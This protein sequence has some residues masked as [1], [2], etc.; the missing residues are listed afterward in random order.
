MS[1]SPF[2]AQ[3]TADGA[4]FE[5]EHCLFDTAPA[6][7]SDTNLLVPLTPYGFVE[8]TGPDGQ[9][10]FQGQTTADFRQVSA[11]QA[12]PGSYCTPKGRMLASFSAARLDED[13]LLLQMRKD[14]IEDTL[15][16][17]AKYAVFSKVKLS[18][19]SESYTGIGL[20][21]PDAK[22]LLS[23]VCETTPDGPLK[24]CA[25]PG[26]IV[27][28]CDEAGQRYELWL[29]PEQAA[30]VWQ[31]LS[32]KAQA[33]SSTHWDGLRIAAGDVPVVAATRDEFLPQ[34]LNYD[35]TG[36]VNFK[37]GCYT[38]QEVV[39]RLHFK[40]VPKR[41]LYLARLEGPAKAGEEVLDGEKTVGMVA[42]SGPDQQVALVLAT[43][44]AD[45]ANL[46]LKG[47]ARVV[48]VTPPPYGF[49]AE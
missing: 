33:V 4:R 37:K 34:F 39:A 3:L 5:G 17:L 35:L 11:T 8:A 14:L 10:F 46:Q 30:E 18:D 40:G 12:R 47:G 19:A 26:G 9:T 31:A 1:T 48:E 45:S 36:A 44:S 29:K 42:L 43:A 22:A 24:T 41:R 6:S 2:I 25:L 27:V 32:S 23:S 15:T 20:V 13:T 28:Q 21:G 49:P 38:G 7:E 16:V